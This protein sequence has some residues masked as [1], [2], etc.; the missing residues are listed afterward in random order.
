VGLDHLLDALERDA[1]AQV[2]RLLGEARAEADRLTAA[3]TESVDRRRREAAA[4]RERSRQQEVER[5]VT[6]ARRD[7]R[8]AVLESRACLVARGIA[9]VR[10]ELPAAA[11]GPAYRTR[12]PVAV[13]SAL[14]AVG[15]APAVIRCPEQLASELERQRPADGVSIVVDP[16]AGSGF[17]L[18]TADGAVEVDETLETRLERRLPELTRHL[19]ARLEVES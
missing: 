12:L 8:R 7:A 2:E 16:G 10:A 4:L 1:N 3:G 15:G 17:R 18:A 19:L 13:M 11:I 5:A 14:T 6:L 9:A